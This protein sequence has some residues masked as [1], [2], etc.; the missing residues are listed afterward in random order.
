MFIKYE[1]EKKIINLNNYD[2]IRVEKSIE[3]H[4]DFFSIIAVKSTT[5][6]H[7]DSGIMDIWSDGYVKKELLRFSSETEANAMYDEIEKAWMTHQT[8]FVIPKP[9]RKCGL[10]ELLFFAD[11]DYRDAVPIR[12]CWIEEK[13]DGFNEYKGSSGC[14]QF[15]IWFLCL[16]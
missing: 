9:T 3:N 12:I 14:W 1:D 15:D 7:S 10:G 13:E 6:I 8:V 2:E 11:K 5:E 4:I 16:F